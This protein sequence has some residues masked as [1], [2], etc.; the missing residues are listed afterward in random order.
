MYN[1]SLD[2]ERFA[3]PHIYFF[4]ENTLSALL[5]KAGF[6]VLQSRIFDASRN[7]SYLQ[8]IAKKCKS[9]ES[10]CTLNGPLDDVSLIID[11]V[12]KN[13]IKTKLKSKKYIFYLG[14]LKRYIGSIKG[15]FRDYYCS[16]SL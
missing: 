3:I 12:R 10:E 5:K 14:F 4:S 16:K 8:I 6:N 1:F 15:N 9:N 7:R 11:K 2:D 13:Q